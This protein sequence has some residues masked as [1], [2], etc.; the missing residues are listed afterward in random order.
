VAQV[1]TAIMSASLAVRAALPLE[2][3]VRIAEETLVGVPAAAVGCPRHCF[4]CCGR[5]EVPMQ[6]TA[7]LARSSGR[8]AAAAMCAGCG[9]PSFVACA[10]RVHGVRLRPVTI[11][12][13]FGWKNCRHFHL[14]AGDETLA[15][16]HRMHG[17]LDIGFDRVLHQTLRL[18]FWSGVGSWSAVAR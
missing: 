11:G 10:P 4:C 1:V 8:G 6:P 12:S 2:L 18:F 3:A 16:R 17:N 15:V 7:Q 9:R 13:R 14:E 5:D